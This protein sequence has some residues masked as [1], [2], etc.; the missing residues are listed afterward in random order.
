MHMATVVVIEPSYYPHNTEVLEI[1]SHCNRPLCP[2][3]LNHANLIQDGTGLWKC[4]NEDCNY[5][6]YQDEMEDQ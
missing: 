6:F 4:S 2:H 5:E 1:C 3:C